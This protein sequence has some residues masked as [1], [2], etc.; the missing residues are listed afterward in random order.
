MSKMVTEAVDM[1]V[2]SGRA[3][4]SAGESRPHPEARFVS[5]EVMEPAPAGAVCKACLSNDLVLSR[6]PGLYSWAR[7]LGMKAYR[8]RQCMRLT[9]W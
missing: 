7:L 9:L 8:C 3:P 5:D 1:M 4:A 6:R 2:T